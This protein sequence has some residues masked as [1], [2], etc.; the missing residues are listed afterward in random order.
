M[1]NRPV[2]RSRS[3][4]A[5]PK[6]SPKRNPRDKTVAMSAYSLSVLAA[7]KNVRACSTLKYRI[8]GFG[9]TGGSTRVATFRGTLPYFTAEFRAVQSVL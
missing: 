4:H 6:P 5:T 9:A 3:G 2:S 8:L 1:S 7:S